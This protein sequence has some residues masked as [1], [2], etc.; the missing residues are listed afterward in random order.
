MKLERFALERFQSIWENRVAWNLAESGVHPL[1]VAE[2]VDCE[3]RDGQQQEP[4]APQGVVEAPV[5]HAGMLAVVVRVTV[6]DSGVAY[7]PR[8]ATFDG[9]NEERGGGVGLALISAWCRVAAYSRARGR[10]RVVFELAVVTADPASPVDGT[11]W[12]FDDAGSPSNI[13]LRI[14]KGGVTYDLPIGT[15]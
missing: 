9:P 11:A 8:G 15:L 1:R 5:R 12:L 7:D 6:V 2:L 13:S 4:T 10:N 14:R 3:R